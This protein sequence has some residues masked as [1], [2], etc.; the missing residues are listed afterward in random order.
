MRFVVPFAC[1]MLLLIAG[2]QTYPRC[3]FRFEIVRPPTVM[4]QVPIDTTHQAAAATTVTPS[5]APA[6]KSGPTLLL[7]PAQRMPA[8]E[9]NKA[10]ETTVP[11]CYPMWLPPC[12]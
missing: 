9:P 10:G 5:F 4:Q 12:Q 8:G 1:M 2:C 3:G 7:T 6:A 11:L